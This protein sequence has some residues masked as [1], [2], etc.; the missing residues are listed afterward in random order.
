MPL[1][2][3]ADEAISMVDALEFYE[4][5]GEVFLKHSLALPYGKRIQNIHRATRALQ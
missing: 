5:D 3:S 2:G 1:K 4:E